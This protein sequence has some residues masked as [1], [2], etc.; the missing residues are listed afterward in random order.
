MSRCVVLWL[1]SLLV[2]VGVTGGCSDNDPAIALRRAGAVIEQDED[3]ERIEK[4]TLPQSAGDAELAEVGRLPRIVELD[5]SGTLVTDA[6]LKHL[7]NL[8]ELK[9]LDL[10]NTTSLTTGWIH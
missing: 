3:R 9:T 6:G 10:S 5:L 1:A 2:L 8:D 7:V 4:I